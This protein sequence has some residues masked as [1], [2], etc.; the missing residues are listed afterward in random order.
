MYVSHFKVISNVTDRVVIA[1]KLYFRCKKST[2]SSPPRII[3]RTCPRRLKFQIHCITNSAI[4][5]ANVLTIYCFVTNERGLYSDRLIYGGKFAFQTRLG[6]PC[7]WKEFVLL[8]IWGQFSKYKPPGTYIWRGDLT[9][10]FLRYRFRGLIF[11]GAYTWRGLFSEF[12]GNTKE[13]F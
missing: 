7:S 8:C 9:E 13:A 2:R 12:Y 4:S 3:N 6:L 1:I 11:G 5:L 10:G